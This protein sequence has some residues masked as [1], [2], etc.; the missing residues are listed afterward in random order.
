M[1]PRSRILLHSIAAAITLLCVVSSAAQEL[2]SRL[3]AKIRRAS[4]EVHIKGQLRGGGALVSN[5]SGKIFVLSAAHLFHTPGDTCTIQT[6][7]EKTHL[8][9]LSSYDLGHDLALIEVDPSLSSYGT[10]KIAGTIPGE[11]SPLF[12]FGPALSRRILVMPGSVSSSRISYTDFSSSG[13][14]IAHFFVS[15]INPAFS[16]GGPWVNRDGEIVGV[17]HGRLKG[18]EGSP[19]SGLSMVTPPDAVSALIESNSV[20]DTQGVGGYLWEIR[21]AERSYLDRLPNGIEGVFVNPVFKNRPFDRAGIKP[22]DLI[23]AC[24]G[25]PIQRLYQFVSLIRESSAGTTFSLEVLTPG[26]K[27]TRQVS[28]TTDSLEAN[29]H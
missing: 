18:D 24:N 25:K 9:S 4:V 2:S 14:Y 29:W 11:T 20:A 21:T 1:T 6:E 10:L 27:A 12:N 26:A 17:Q 28:L 16:S 15:G 23:I 5:S 3:V 8:A 7:D 13:D 22:F 19:Y